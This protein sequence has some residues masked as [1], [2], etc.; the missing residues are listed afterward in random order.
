M[1]KVGVTLQNGSK[2]IVIHSG[3]EENWQD[4]VKFSRDSF[5][6]DVEQ[7]YILV[8]TISTFRFEGRANE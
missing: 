1:I 5:V 7:N 4:L 2:H 8:S 3:D 6:K